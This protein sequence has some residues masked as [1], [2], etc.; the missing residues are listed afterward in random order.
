VFRF[1]SRKASDGARFLALAAG[2]VG[3]RLTYNDLTSK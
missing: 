2:V 1:N 3:K